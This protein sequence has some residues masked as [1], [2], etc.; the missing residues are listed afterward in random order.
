M[1]HIMMPCAAGLLAATMK[2]AAWG[3]LAASA[4]VK[5]MAPARTLLVSAANGAAGLF[6]CGLR[7]DALPE[8]LALPAGSV[9][10]GYGGA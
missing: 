7:R 9:A 8:T 1:L 4:K 6:V 10:G 5:A 3:V 2:M